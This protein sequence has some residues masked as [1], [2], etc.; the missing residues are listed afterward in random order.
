MAARSALVTLAI[1]AGFAVVLTAARPQAVHSDP[2]VEV[3]LPDT[4]LAVTELV[5]T[6]RDAAR[7]VPGTEPDRALRIAFTD[8]VPDADDRPFV[9]GQQHGGTVWVR[10]EGL[11]MPTR[12]LLHEVAHALAPGA[13]HGDTFRA[14]YLAAIAEVYDEAT[15]AREARRL[16]W[17]YDKCYTDDSCPEVPRDHSGR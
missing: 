7:G 17:V 4:E 6:V 9:A 8:A 10:I 16:A 1:V 14:T 3:V 15:A 13:G 11:A 5:G 12:T 2:S